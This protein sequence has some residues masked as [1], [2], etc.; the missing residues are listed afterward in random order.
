VK[1]QTKHNIASFSGCSRPLAHA[2]VDAA[3]AAK[4][5]EDAGPRL[6]KVV[7]FVI[8]GITRSELRAVYEISKATGEEAGMVGTSHL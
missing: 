1:T 3:K 8:G 5:E 6:R 2:Q 4:G 7:L